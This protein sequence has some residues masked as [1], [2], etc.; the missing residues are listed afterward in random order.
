MQYVGDTYKKLPNPKRT[1]YTFS[2]WYYNGQ[3]VTN[4]TIVEVATDHTLTAKWTKGMYTVTFDTDGAGNVNPIAV[5]YDETYGDGLP[6]KLSKTGYI[7]KGWEDSKGNKIT[8][9]SKVA[10]AS[11][12]TLTAVWEPIIYYV[13]YNANG[14]SGSTMSYTTHTYDKEMSLRLN[15]YKKDGYEFAGWAISADGTKKYNDGQTVKNLASTNGYIYNLYAKWSPNNYT[16]KYNANGGT[17]AP[18][19]QTKTHDSTLTL[20]SAKPSRNGYTFL[21]WSE[22]SSATRATYQPSDKFTVNK[23]T[24]LYAVW[25]QNTYTIV[26]NANGGTGAPTNQTKYHDLATTLSSIKPSRAGYIFL[27]W[28]ESSTAT[29]ATYQPSERFT[30]NKNTILYA[31]WKNNIYT[32]TFNANGGT[33]SQSSKT[34][35]QGEKY[36]T[37]PTPV[38][39]GYTF[40]GWY[41]SK[42]GGTRIGSDTIMTDS[43]ITVY[44]QWSQISITITEQY[45]DTCKGVVYYG[46]SKTLTINGLPSGQTVTWKTSNSSVVSLNKTSGQ[47]IYATGKNIG[48]ATVTATITGT[49]IST[50]ITLSVPKPVIKLSSY[51]G[52]RTQ[53][54]TSS[55]YSLNG[56]N[57]TWWYKIELPKAT[58]SNTGMG[59]AYYSGWDNFE[60][61]VAVVKN[62][63]LYVNSL[64]CMK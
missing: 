62:G 54:A 59:G 15:T 20:R 52:S 61:D 24:T 21:G 51:S 23:N 8:A 43:N 35:Q 1:G 29:Y 2:G 38:R 4:K 9:T 56:D 34:V 48:S 32:I 45:A 6:N 58:V 10:I 39:D 13:K 33:V 55:T 63:V 5:N 7:F 47:Q 19:S 28:S 31:V 3:P 40:N 26:Y 17:G 46:G 22:S 14:G 64:V 25:Q 49:N 11:E 44:A 41:T 53:S 18:E 37:L 16:I 30:A 36:G 60:S 57:I 12:H 42:S 27:G 50:S